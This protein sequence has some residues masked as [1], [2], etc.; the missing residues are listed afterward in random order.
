NGPDAVVVS[1]VADAVARVAAGFERVRPLRVSHAFHSGLMEP[2]L[3]EFGAAIEGLE[4]AAPRLPWVTHGDPTTADYWVA[5]VRE[6]VRFMDLVREMENR[7][8]T[9]FLE[10]GPGATLSAMG[11]ECVRDPRAAFIPTMRH[12]RDEPEALISAL[13]HAW[14]RGAGVDWK[15][16]LPEAGPVDL[17]TYPFAR[18]RYWMSPVPV[19]GQDTTGHPVLTTVVNAPDA[20]TVTLTGRLSLQRHP[21]LADHAV[22][23]VVLLPGTGLVELVLRAAREVGSVTIDELALEAPLVV[24]DPGTVVQV[25]VGEP[26]DSG[27]RRLRV[28]SRPDGGE[29]R[30]HATG[31]VTQAAVPVPVD[32]DLVMWPPR[33]AQPI[34]VGG[35]YDELAGRGYAYGP[36]FRGLRAAWRRGDEIFA[37]VALPDE[38]DAT[39]FAVHPALLDACWH[40]VLLGGDGAEPV[41][42][43]AWTGVT[44]HADAGSRVRVR[45]SAASDPTT[46]ETTSMTVADPA[47]RVLLEVT[48][49]AVRPVSAGQ[50]PAEPRSLYRVTPVTVAAPAPGTRRWAIL[51]E[52]ARGLGHPTHPRLDAIPEPLPD[53]VTHHSPV[54][55]GSI[56]AA[57][58]DA[59]VGLLRLL[60]EWLTD[61]RWAAST[62]VLTIGDHLSQTAVAGLVRAAQAEHPGRIVLVHGVSAESADPDVLAR[63][64]ETGEPEVIVHG[65]EIRVPRLTKAGGFGKPAEIEGPVLITGGTGGLGALVARH[66]VTRH[67]VRELVLV[68]RRG[69]KAPR[70]GLIQASLEELGA[71]VTIAACDAADRD[72]LAALLADHPVRAVVH[73]AGVV[74][75]AVV[76][77]LTPQSVAAVLRSKVD[78]AW[79]LHELTTG[80][81]AFVLFSSAASTVLAAGQGNYAVGNVFLD[82]LAVHRRALGLPAL[83]LGWGLWE[84]QYGMAAELD[85]AGRQ[86]MRRLGMPPL[87]MDE[88]LALFDASLAAEDAVVLPI[89]FDLAVLRARADEAPA[90]L[91]GLAPRPPAR[92]AS[93]TEGLARRLTGMAP[94]DREEFLVALVSGQVAAVL[95]HQDPGA[96][97]VGRAFSE[98]GFDSLSAVELRNALGVATGLRLPATLVFDHPT[99]TALARRL[100]EELGEGGTDHTARVLAEVDRL[101]EVLDGADADRAA[102][103]A[104]LEVLLRSLRDGSDVPDDDSISDDISD[105][106]TD[107]ELFA[108]LDKELG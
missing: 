2:M 19:A 79:N 1:G 40:P 83:S 26:D 12:E 86:R 18:R 99:V 38:A 23:G 31:F 60:A 11:A 27:R 50:L 88:A 25:D 7:G 94:A 85:E 6:P 68:S 58:H 10:I 103:A 100:A 101:Q 73:A 81:S 105:D 36:W 106:I 8:V 107:D 52:D 30:R 97:D 108:V 70:A 76:T 78:A 43:F 4:F 54:R 66:L 57:V 24:T 87:G 9:T 5:Q 22:H 28:H 42:P 35:G 48:G 55:G 47:G 64:V 104:R 92:R 13:S 56:P 80:L 89:R 16:V 102:V 77:S 3:A 53:V 39:G 82:Q 69:P 45:I 75:N 37:E 91:R 62:L 98:L 49:L 32:L 71:N 17:P 61:A 33:D 90:M 46:S 74:D 67:G 96:I 21:W 63:A 41:V 59:T 15:R 84:E 20:D 93:A 95:G 72:A 14:V 44:L 34:D 29:W 51:G 65:A